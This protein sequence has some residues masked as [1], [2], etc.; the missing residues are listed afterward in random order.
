MRKHADKK[1]VGVGITGY[2]YRQYTGWQSKKPK[3]EVLVCSK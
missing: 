1:A 3:T 2:L